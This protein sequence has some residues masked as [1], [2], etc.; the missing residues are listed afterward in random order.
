MMNAYSVKLHGKH[1][2][3]TCYR[4]IKLWKTSVKLMCGKRSGQTK[5]ERRRQTDPLLK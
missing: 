3:W 5:S 1:D 2:N 4:N